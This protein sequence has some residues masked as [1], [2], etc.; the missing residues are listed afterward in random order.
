MP[1]TNSPR[2]IPTTTFGVVAYQGSATGS[3]GVVIRGIYYEAKDVYG[4]A[5]VN[6]A[7]VV[8]DYLPASSQWLIVGV[9]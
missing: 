9:L 1:A 3:F 5:P 7:G 8:L 2:G 4:L 6:G